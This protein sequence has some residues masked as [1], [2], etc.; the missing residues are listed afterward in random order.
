MRL[1]IGVIAA[2][3]LGCGG[4]SADAPS[5]S[6]AAEIPEELV[7][8]GE[9]IRAAYDALDPSVA[10]LPAVYR[11]PQQLAAGD[12]VVNPEGDVIATATEAAVLTW[13]DLFPLARFGHPGRLTLTHPETNAVLLSV[14]TRLWPAEVAGQAWDP[15]AQEDALVPAPNPDDV[16][17]TLEGEATGALASALTGPASTACTPRR[18]MFQVRGTHLGAADFYAAQQGD[19][20]IM[21]SIA[22]AFGATAIPLGFGALGTTVQDI[23]DELEDRDLTCCDEVIFYYT[24]HGFCGSGDLQIGG[25]DFLTPSDISSIINGSKACKWLLIMD[26]CH[27]GQT[28]AKI[29]DAVEK[30]NLGGT[31]HKGVTAVAAAEASDTSSGGIVNGRNGG[32]FTTL[33]GGAI[34]GSGKTEYTW[35]EATAAWVGQTGKTLKGTLPGRKLGNVAAEWG[36][37]LVGASK[38]FIK[39]NGMTYDQKPNYQST[40]VGESC[41][42]CGGALPACPDDP[43]PCKTWFCNTGLCEKANVSDGCACDQDGDEPLVCATRQCD[44]GKCVEEK[45]PGAQCDDQD[46][47]TEQDV[48]DDKA[49]CKGTL[50]TCPDDG[51]PCT[52]DECVDGACHKPLE[53]GAICKT[54]P[55]CWKAGTCDAAGEC[56]GEEALDGLCVAELSPEQFEC[57]VSSCT[58]AGCVYKPKLKALCVLDGSAGH[59]VKDEAAL[60]DGATGTLG[61]CEPTEGPCKKDTDCKWLE[62]EKFGT[63]TTTAAFNDQCGHVTC[64][65]P[66]GAEEGVC[67]VAFEPYSTPCNKGNPCADYQCSGTGYCNIIGYKEFGAEEGCECE[68]GKPM[69]GQCAPVVESLGADNACVILACVPKGDGTK[70]WCDATPKDAECDPG[71][72]HCW[73]GSCSVNFECLPASYDNTDLE[74]KPEVCDDSNPCTT[75]ACVGPQDVQAD[76]AGCSHVCL[77]EDGAACPDDP[78]E[79][80][81]VFQGEGCPCVETCLFD[82]DC[83]DGE[84]CTDEWCGEDGF[85]VG[86]SLEDGPC[87][88]GDPC[89]TEDSCVTGKCAG[90][91]ME[92]EQPDDEC[93]FAACN[94]E[95]LQCEVTSWIPNYDDPSGADWMVDFGGFLGCDSI[96]SCYDD[97]KDDSCQGGPFS[98]SCPDAFLPY[99]GGCPSAKDVQLAT[100]EC[101]CKQ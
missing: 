80:A 49:E 14:E 16:E 37:W 54:G 43:A 34:V 23:K 11:Y 98:G 10:R 47:C 25:N 35:P 31:Q 4:G 67:D 41:C 6:Q 71:E 19:Q 96:Q 57:T 15:F 97:L 74:A 66:D 93:S 78:Q 91:P 82:E 17:W 76:G 24:G 3:V 59:C 20:Q 13:A 8:I 61:V 85:C 5:G 90:I 27:S 100:Q 70:G 39:A 2:L 9:E 87:D 58:A 28:A 81:C 89:T 62:A 94:P 65:I 101:K 56:E 51:K 33:A 75:D 21:N 46:A 45:T 18:L 88:D 26:S 95:T 79:A 22:N 1:Q 72:A 73:T 32:I 52:L 69:E 84:D 63:Q 7:P 40:G 92:C 53:A 12:Q 99:N 48:C 50:I 86:I 68:P 38:D 83:D 64:V 77:E 44:D 36:G 42:K 29:K 55:T 30:E 60:P